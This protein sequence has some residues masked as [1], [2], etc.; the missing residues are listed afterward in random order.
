MG[1]QFQP[2][3]RLPLERYATLLPSAR[4]REINAR[5]A[6]LRAILA[7]RVVWNV[8]STA[9][10][11]GVAEMVRSLL[12][13]ARGAGVDARWAV[14]EAPPR[15]FHITKRL[16][17]ALH[18]T[19]GDGS[20]LGRVERALFESVSK[21]NADLLVP[22]VRPRDV[23]IVHD[24]QPAGMIPALRQRGAHVVWRCHIGADEL[25][26]EA[27]RGW[28]FLMPYLRSAS[29]SVFSRS[30]YAPPE[31]DPSRVAIIPPRID[32]FSP[33]NAPLDAPTV[34]AILVAAGLL[35][36]P[37]QGAP[38][39]YPCEDGTPGR[40][41]R[42]AE[43]VSVDGPLDPD[44]PLV[45]QVS[46]WDR[47]KDPIGVM[48]GFLEIDPAVR[49]TLMLVGPGLS[50]VADDPES[51]E[52]YDEVLA[53]WRS[54]PIATRRRVC[55]AKLPNVDVG[56]NAAMVNALQR[57]ATIV[58]QKSLQEG[59]GLT[60]AEAMWKERPV[61][62]SAVGGIPDQIDHGV[63]GVL[64]R[65]PRDPFAFAMEAARLLGDPALC[66]T[67]GRRARARVAERFLGVESLLSYGALIE[68]LDARPPQ[69]TPQ[70]P[71]PH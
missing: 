47:L 33:K 5:V 57:H 2:E 52:V 22:L 51:A 68:Q 56:E 46:R 19:A 12:A 49:A 31:L 24:P 10:G 71:A 43:L 55:L 30:A 63:N 65:D 45:V 35:S 50:D 53:A 42:K 38:A 17:H 15:F 13:Y 54:L 36:G 44:M 20:A 16:H 14:I 32:P 6:Q 40:V 28:R 25:N 61:I 59:F 18:G 4:M 8:S 21:A 11:G 69:A 37:P 29:G 67:F 26:E 3:P 39:V 62:A 48:R 64:L 41:D 66:A 1:L 58:V 60:V 27:R 7:G 9:V 70:A 34:R 23:V